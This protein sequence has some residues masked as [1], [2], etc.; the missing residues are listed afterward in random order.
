MS[1]GRID[2]EAYTQI[3]EADDGITEEQLVAFGLS[4]I[5]EVERCYEELDSIPA[6]E[7]LNKMH[8]DIKWLERVESYFLADGSFNHDADF[9]RECAVNNKYGYRIEVIDGV[10][11]DVHESEY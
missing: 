1:E 3:F 4:A 2:I 7:A 9:V 11:T 6:R 8:D 5:S 10:E